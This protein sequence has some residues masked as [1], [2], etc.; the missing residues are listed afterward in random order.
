MTINLLL[1]SSLAKRQ[2]EIALIKN[3]WFRHLLWAP[4]LFRSD[5]KLQSGVQQT[6]YHELFLVQ[7]WENL[8]QQQQATVEKKSGHV[9]NLDF[10]LTEC[11]IMRM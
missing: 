7:L 3:P 9:E 4:H 2:K 1:D 10:L 6:D 11:T 8:Q 5:K